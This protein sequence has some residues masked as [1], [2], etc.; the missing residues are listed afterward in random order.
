MKHRCPG[1][2]KEPGEDDPDE[3]QTVR[4]KS[5]TIEGMGSQQGATGGFIVGT[6]HAVYTA[7]GKIG[8]ITINADGTYDFYTEKD[9]SGELKINY[10]GE[11]GSDEKGW[12]DIT[13][14]TLTIKV[15]PVADAPEIP[16]APVETP[17][18]TRVSL[19]LTVPVLKDQTDLTGGSDNH[20]NPERL[21]EITLSG[22]PAGAK[23]YNGGTELTLTGGSVT[24]TITDIPGYHTSTAS[25]AYQMTTDKYEAL[26]VLP[27]A[28]T[29]NNFSITVSATS[30]EVDD[31]GNILK[32]SEGH[33]ISASNSA[34][35][36]VEV[37]ADTDGS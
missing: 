37:L 14:R 29:H 33:D 22:F 34:T 25:G 12:T 11:S 24:I 27:P 20:D 15:T 5:Y 16:V 18:D 17:E 32:D 35:I 21:G 9:Y 26:E 10:E 7:G 13:G 6:E 36:K 30:Y 19:G 23:L 2:F 4:I 31:E 8:K 28:D 3:G 1:L